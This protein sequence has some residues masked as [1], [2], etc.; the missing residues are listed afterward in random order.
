V[1][2]VENVWTIGDCAQIP[3]PD[4]PGDFYPPTAQHALRQGKTV[5]AN[6]A[7]ALAGADP[8]P[9]RFRT[10]GLLVGLGHRTAAAEIRGF[11]FSGFA[12]WFLWRGIYWSKL[13]G[14][15]K[16]LRV[17]LDWTIDLFFP[18]DIVVTGPLGRSAAAAE[19]A[20]TEAAPE[21]EL[22]DAS[23]DA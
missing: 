19:V 23:R 21:H 2:G 16:K 17:A 20:T 7:G 12:A 22:V 9:F 5:A 18:R 15:E 13:P 3:D 8:K 10:L 6:I 11:R 14:L 1:P 4:R